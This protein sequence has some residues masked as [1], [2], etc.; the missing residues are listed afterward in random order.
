MWLES[1]ALLGMECYVLY[2]I[3]IIVNE[4]M[5][6]KLH[7]HHNK[8]HFCSCLFISTRNFTKYGFFG[9]DKKKLF[10]SLSLV[11]LSIYIKNIVK[12]HFSVEYSWGDRSETWSKD[13]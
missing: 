2:F 3:I 10:L 6:E 4:E 1:A 13:Q 8:D 5:S 9:Q 11:K 7:F 12:N